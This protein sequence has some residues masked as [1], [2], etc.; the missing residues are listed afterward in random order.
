VIKAI[1]SSFCNWGNCVRVIHDAP[2]VHVGHTGGGEQLTFTEEQWK[3]FIQGVQNHEFDFGL[4][5]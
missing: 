3:V 5:P 4:L 2:V 1:K